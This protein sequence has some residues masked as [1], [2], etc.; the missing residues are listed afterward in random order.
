MRRRFLT[1]A[2]AALVVAVA[3]P[4]GAALTFDAPRLGSAA[5]VRPASSHGSGAPAE[6]RR[7]PEAGSLVVTGG[8]LLGLAAAVKRAS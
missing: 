2:L 1:I 8:L 6:S 4:L 5:T 3:V 7:L